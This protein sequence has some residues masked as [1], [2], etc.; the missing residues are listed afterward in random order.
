MWPKRTRAE[1]RKVAAR[2]G[3]LR[4]RLRSAARRTRPLPLSRAA[5]R[6]WSHGAVAGPPCRRHELGL[7]AQPIRRADGRARQVVSRVRQVAVQELRGPLGEQR[8]PRMWLAANVQTQPPREP[9]RLPRPS[10]ARSSPRHSRVLAHAAHSP[11][12]A[13]QLTV[14]P[15]L[16]GPARGAVAKPSMRRVL[17]AVPALQPAP[18]VPR[19]WPRRPLP[20]PRPESEADVVVPQRA[21]WRQCTA[22]GLSRWSPCPVRNASDH[23]G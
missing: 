1:G 12:R 3:E 23:R 21:L 22:H 14:A 18:L 16:A 8:V 7:R 13:R 19:R 6:R 15:K 5:Q 10:R 2:A 17:P 20:A 11:P 9:P 4:R